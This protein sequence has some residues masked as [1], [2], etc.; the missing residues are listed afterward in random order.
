VHPESTET[1]NC[2]TEDLVGVEA[3]EF[4]GETLLEGAAGQGDPLVGCPSWVSSVTER[5]G[6]DN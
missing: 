6:R 3:A 2:F 4:F 5:S 1:A